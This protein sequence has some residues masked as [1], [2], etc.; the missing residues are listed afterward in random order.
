MD[1]GGNEALEFVDLVIS[2]K[3]DTEETI[4]TKV[5]T[6]KS[7]LDKRVAAEVEKIFKVNGRVPEKSGTG[8]PEEGD[9][10]RGAFG[11]ANNSNSRKKRGI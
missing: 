9:Y 5:N 3:D 7:F 11:L 6:V 2:G 10:L 4:K 1:D 8:E